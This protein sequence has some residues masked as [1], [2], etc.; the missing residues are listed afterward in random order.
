LGQ[1]LLHLVHLHIPQ[2][3]P[4]VAQTLLCQLLVIQLEGHI[5]C[6]VEV[7]LGFFEVISDVGNVAE[8]EEAVQ[9]ELFVLQLLCHLQAVF[10]VQFGLVVLSDDEE[11]DS[12]LAIA[13]ALTFILLMLEGPLQCLSEELIRL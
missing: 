2:C 12:K 8:T 7:V 10:K 9:L 6:L 1:S 13:D 11:G 3:N 5:I 4:H